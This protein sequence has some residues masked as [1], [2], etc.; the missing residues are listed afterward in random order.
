M[1][2]TFSIMSCFRNS[3]NFDSAFSIKLYGTLLGFCFG[4]IDS[5]I[6]SATC[7]ALYFSMFPSKTFGNFPLIVLKVVPLFVRSLLIVL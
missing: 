3:F 4:V 1:S 6:E 5:S 2:H 7:L